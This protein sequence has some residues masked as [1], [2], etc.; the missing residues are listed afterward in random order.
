M[1]EILTFNFY[2]KHDDFSPNFV[3]SS[4]PVQQLC[5][6][7]DTNGGSSQTSDMSAEAPDCR[8]PK[9]KKMVRYF[10]NYLVATKC[11]EVIVF[12]F[13]RVE[14]YVQFGSELR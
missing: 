13:F 3:E 5:D 8:P 6:T 11:I 12:E 9:R 2:S 10:H 7:V 14:A 1:S 4:V